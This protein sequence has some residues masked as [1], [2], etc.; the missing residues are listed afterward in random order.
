MRLLPVSLSSTPRGLLDDAT[1]S[2]CLCRSGWCF[3]SSGWGFDLISTSVRKDNLH[4]KARQGRRR[5]N[6]FGTHPPLVAMPD[7]PP[8]S[9][10]PAFASNS[11]LARVYERNPAYEG[12]AKDLASVSMFDGHSGDTGM[13]ANYTIPHKEKGVSL[14]AAKAA[15]HTAERVTQSEPV[16]WFTPQERQMA[17]ENLLCFV[18]CGAVCHG[19]WMRCAGQAM[20]YVVDTP[21]RLL[22]HAGVAPRTVR[23]LYYS[24]VR[25]AVL[26]AGLALLG[27]YRIH[28]HPPP[29]LINAF[30]FIILCPLLAVHVVEALGCDEHAYLCAASNFWE[31]LFAPVRRCWRRYMSHCWKQCCASQRCYWTFGRD[32]TEFGFTRS[33]REHM[34]SLRSATPTIRWHAI[35]YHVNSHHKN[36]RTRYNVSVTHYATSRYEGI[37]WVRD[38]TEDAEAMLLQQMLSATQPAPMASF[39]MAKAFVFADEASQ[40]HY[41]WHMDEF[42]RHNERDEQV[43]VW[44]TLHIPGFVDQLLAVTPIDSGRPQLH[45]LRRAALTLA[46]YYCA[47]ILLLTAPFRCWLDTSSTPLTLTV[48]KEIAACN[49]AHEP[50]HGEPHHGGAVAKSQA[51]VGGEGSDGVVCPICGKRLKTVEG[52]WQHQR[53]VHGI[54][55]Q[56]T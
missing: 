56:V 51:A 14:E 18:L 54:S 21:R 28:N 34:A 33:L 8:P 20:R 43:H 52:M 53:D 4:E 26:W 50:R 10:P 17:Q 49:L 44:T 48:I 36:G 46:A 6:M 22:L 31:R 11:D 23:R 45:L 12:K 40:R 15:T 55:S 3:Y 38:V 27:W 29:P 32:D 37:R 1:P 16:V 9:A 13:F 25:A 2:G 5:S 41:Q 35:S 19:T 42:V 39:C 7:P 24:V 30:A 47:A